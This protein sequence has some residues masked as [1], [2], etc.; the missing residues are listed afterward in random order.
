[1]TDE[2]FAIKG[3]RAALAAHESAT[4]YEIDD[5]YH[6]ILMLAASLIEL[7]WSSALRGDAAIN[8]SKLFAEAFEVAEA[9]RS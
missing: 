8:M 5:E 7:G 6:G 1:M 9:S 4:G 3:A 2:S